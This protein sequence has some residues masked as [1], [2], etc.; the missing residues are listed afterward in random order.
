FAFHL[1]PD[2]VFHAVG[3]GSAIV[4]W[5]SR[6]PTS[7]HTVPRADGVRGGFGGRCEVRRGTPRACRSAREVDCAQK[8]TP[9]RTARGIAHAGTPQRTDLVGV[10]AGGAR[11]GA[12]SQLGR[13]RTGRMERGD[14]LRAASVGRL[15]AAGGKP[16]GAADGGDRARHDRG[17]LPAVAGGRRIE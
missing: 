1:V 4:P 17:G 3:S 14:S 9:A 7:G 11:M 12:G 15:P 8:R 2:V 5:G 10:E 13:Y 6:R 16:S